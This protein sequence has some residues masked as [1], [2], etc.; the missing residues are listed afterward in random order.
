MGRYPTPSPPPVS[1]PPMT[2]STRL[3]PRSLP[4]SPRLSAPLLPEVVP[5]EAVL[6]NN[7]P[8]ADVLLDV[9]VCPLLVQF[10]VIQAVPVPAPSPV[11]LAPAPRPVPQPAPLRPAPTSGNLGDLFGN[12]NTVR[13][14][15]PDFNI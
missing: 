12:G 11:I 3:S 8:V 14:N 2:L 13:I 9:S 6:D 1:P 5:P 10:P 4:S 15:T 7:P